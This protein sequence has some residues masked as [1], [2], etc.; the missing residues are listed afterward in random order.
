ME[1]ILLKELRKIWKIIPFAIRKKPISIAAASK[2]VHLYNSL[3]VRK[4]IDKF[5]ELTETETAKFS[6]TTNFISW[7]TY[8]WNIPLKQRPQHIAE[9]LAMIDGV[10]Y[11]FC[12]KNYYD[13][14]GGVQ[15]LSKNL[16]LVDNFW[17]Y[18]KVCTYVH[19]YA[20]DPTLTLRRFKKI[21]KLNKPIIYEILDEIHEDLQ[22]KVSKSV[23]TRHS[24]ALASKKVA[25]IIITAKNMENK[26]PQTVRP[27]IQYIPNAC[28]SNHFLMQEIP[29][30]KKV[31]GYFGALASWVDYELISFLA[32][33]NPGW[34][35]KLIGMDYDGSIWKSGILNQEN[36]TYLGVVDYQSLPSEIPFSVA[37]LPFRVNDIT[38][39]TSPIKIYE[40]LSS[41]FPVVSTPL[42]ECESIS[43]VSIGIG[44]EDFEEKIKSAMVVDSTKNRDERRS[45]AIEHSWKARATAYLAT[46]IDKEANTWQK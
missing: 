13:S 46:S 3:D 5:S 41:G 45:F 12:T 15:R 18:S 21:E 44:Y 25:K 33:R 36:V 9:Q 42:P 32:K 31:V 38:I 6:E 43:Y 2:I 29:I 37:I 14:L 8:D 40:Y 24:Y 23:I 39:S 16:Y 30:E 17:K 19:V 10:Q 20:T 28:D 35:I 34:T 26:L 7:P 27:K 11:I 22:G 1:K 4:L